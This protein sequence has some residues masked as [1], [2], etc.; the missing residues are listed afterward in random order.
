M[1][2][3]R[4]LL[5]YSDL[6]THICTFVCMYVCSYIAMS[7]D[8]ITYVTGFSKTV[9][10]HTFGIMRNINL[11]YLSHCGC[12]VLDCSHANLRSVIL[13]SYFCWLAITLL[14]FQQHFHNYCKCKS[15]MTLIRGG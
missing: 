13:V 3:A 15:E 8:V 9:P 2:I 6:Q 11:E 1:Y 4:W 12:L 5:I 14:D 10:N 7:I